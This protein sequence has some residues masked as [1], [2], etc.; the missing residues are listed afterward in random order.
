MKPA[1]ALLLFFLASVVTASFGALFTPGEWY[2]SLIK[3]DWTP[4]GWLFGPVWSLLYA[5]IAVSGWLVWRAAGWSGA[6][7]ALTVFLGHLLLNALWSWLF[8]GLQRPDLA[9]ID[10]VLLEATILWLVVLFWPVSW[11]A[12]ALLLPYLAW[13]AFA[14]ALNGAIWQLNP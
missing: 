11:L 3:P 10:I 6:R 13:V 14:T 1:I 7:L 5:M 9:L 8:F 12:G 2:Q 4:P